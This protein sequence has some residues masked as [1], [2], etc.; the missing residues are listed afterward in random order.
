VREVEPGVAAIEAAP[1][2]DRVV[3]VASPSL[4]PA[5]AAAVGET[6]AAAAAPP[7]VAVNRAPDHGP[8]LV[9]ADVLVPDTPVGARLALAGRE[10]RGWLGR[11]VQQL[12]D[13]CEPS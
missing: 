12:A 10:A 3:L 13:L 2:V 7:V 5:L 9:A 1:L 11:S 4:E 8:W 6:I